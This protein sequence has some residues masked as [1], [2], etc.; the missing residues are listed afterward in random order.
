V[1]IAPQKIKLPNGEWM[2]TIKKVANLSW[3]I[4]G[5]TFHT[6][7]IVLDRLPYDAILGYDWLQTNSP[8]NCD[9]QAKTLQF[10]HSGK[11]VTL[12]G[13]QDPPSTPGP[14]SAKTGV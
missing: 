5:H 11:L 4:Q 2:T 9:W 13:L 12:H 7:M 14:I 1:P 3:L 10:T 8:M 6:N